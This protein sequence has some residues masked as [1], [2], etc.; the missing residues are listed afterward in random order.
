MS[1]GLSRSELGDSFGAF[2]HGVL[3]QL[4]RQDQP[5]CCLDLTGSDSWLLVVASQLG[6]LCGNLLEDVI[7]EG[8]QNGHGL[9]ADAS[10]RVDLQVIVLLKLKAQEPCI[11]GEFYVAEL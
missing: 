6:C 9:G 7:D 10:V 4:S 1:T 5:N 3:G 2:R 11:Q 8:I